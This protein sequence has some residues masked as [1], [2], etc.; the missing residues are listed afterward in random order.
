MVVAVPPLMVLIP[1][2]L[3]LGFKVAPPVISFMASLAVVMDGS[4]E[5]GFGFFHRMLAFRPIVGVRHRNGCEPGKR[6]H[7]HYCECCVSN[8]SNQSFL[9]SIAAE[10]CRGIRPNISRIL[11]VYSPA[12]RSGTCC[13]SD[14]FGFSVTKVH[15]VFRFNL[16]ALST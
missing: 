9:L 11:E 3:A 7:H 1:A 15:G 2:V 16:S 5:V 10:V 14:G 6:G 13:R 12:M 4:V 8:S